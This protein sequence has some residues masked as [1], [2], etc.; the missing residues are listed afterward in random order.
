MKNE[1]ITITCYARE[2]LE[3]RRDAFI[4]VL[5]LILFLYYVMMN[6]FMLTVN[7]FVWLSLI[8]ISLF[9]YVYIIPQHNFKSRF[10][11]SNKKIIAGKLHYPWGYFT[12]FYVLKGDKKDYYFLR[13]HFFDSVF[14]LVVP[15]EKDK[16]KK[17]F[18]LLRSKLLY[19][20]W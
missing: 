18:N 5:L 1:R 2:I 11:F 15:V 4:F 9:L 16:S 12:S 19:E 6:L 7:G 8:T 13:G 14:P 3:F 20:D 17:M 10:V